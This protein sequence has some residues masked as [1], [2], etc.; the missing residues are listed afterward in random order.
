MNL[1]LLYFRKVISFIV[2]YIYRRFGGSNV[3]MLKGVEQSTKL[4]A[5]L[6]FLPLSQQVQPVRKFRDRFNISA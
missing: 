3:S 6:C 2:I 1:I 4:V 5:E